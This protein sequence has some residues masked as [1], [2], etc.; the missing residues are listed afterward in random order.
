MTI[1]PQSTRFRG[2]RD[3]IAENEWYKEPRWSVD[4]LLDAERFIGD[5]LDPCCGAGTIP[6]AFNDRGLPCYGNDIVDR[7]NGRFNVGDYFEGAVDI[8]GMSNVVSNPPF[9]M[10]LPFIDRSLNLASHKVAVLARLAFLET[11][12]RKEFFLSRP[13]A[14]VLVFSKRVSMPPAGKGIP[15]KG[16]TVAFAWFVFDKTHRGPNGQ[17]LPASLGFV[18]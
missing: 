9:S 11:P 15:E 2:P 5:T 18:P 8:G 17:P 13:L 10:L 14:R 3:P 16:G 7:S 1:V 4:A 12:G 6:D